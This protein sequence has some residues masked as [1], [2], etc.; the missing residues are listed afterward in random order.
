[1]PSEESGAGR[2]ATVHPTEEPDGRIA[3]AMRGDPAALTA[4]WE[5]HRRW[6]AAILLAHK[7]AFEEL[8]DLLQEVAMTMVRRIDTLREAGSFRPWLRTVA[9]NAARATARSGRV[10]LGAERSARN[11]AAS[12]WRD[13]DS[14]ESEWVR[15]MLGRVARLPEA[16]REPLLLR[17]MHGMRSRQI[18]DIIGVEPATVDTRIARARRMVRE[19]VEQDEEADGARHAAHLAERSAV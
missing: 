19:L 14:A 18:A 10:R 11:L 8:E 3:A 6:V 4:L 17:S 7:P 1:M 5:E 16:Y 9:V 2:T 15:L 13:V 12:E